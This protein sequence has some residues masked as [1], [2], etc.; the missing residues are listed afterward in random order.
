[1]MRRRSHLASG[2]V[3]DERGTS[4]ASVII[5]LMIVLLIAE[6]VVVGGRIASAH[7]TVNNAAREA[8]RRGSLVLSDFDV[9]GA[10]DTTAEDNLERNGQKCT[11]I[12]TDSAGSDFRPGG[13]VVANVTCT[14]D[15]SD[16]SGFGLPL[17]NVEIQA[18]HREIVER[19]RAV[20][21]I[22]TYQGGCPH[23]C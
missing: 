11:P 3:Q 14:V 23:A 7:A 16:M 12:E 1:M 13:F 19:Y 21:E 2:F 8:A 5:V 9:E 15:L 6:L 18:T 4:P 17:P 10:V 22:G 20:G